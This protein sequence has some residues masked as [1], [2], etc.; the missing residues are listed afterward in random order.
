MI[1]AFLLTVIVDGVTVS[2][3]DMLFEDVYECNKFANAIERGELG[4]NQRPYKWQENIT[5]HCVPKMVR[6]N[7]FLFK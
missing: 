7:T 1:M 4:P 3:P 5:A 2:T 6:E